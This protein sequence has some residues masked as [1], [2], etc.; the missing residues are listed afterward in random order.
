MIGALLSL[1]LAPPQACARA[2]ELAFYAG[3][4]G[5]DDGG[6]HS[7]AWQLEYRQNLWKYLDASF[8]YAN[9]GHVPGHHRDG[10]SLQVWAV[11]P[12]LKDRFTLALGVGPY[13]YADTQDQD[14]PPG[15]KDAHD[16]GMI[17]S[18]SFTWYL[19]RRWLMRVNVNEIEAGAGAN[20]RSYVLGLGYRLDQLATDLDQAFGTRPGYAD[21]PNEMTAFVGVTILNSENSENAAAVGLEYRR[22][23]ASYFQL[24]GAWFNEEA[25]ADKRYNSLA[26]QAWLVKSWPE[27][28]VSLGFGVGPNFALGDHV[29][30]DGRALKEVVGLASMTA[31]WRFS[32]ALQARLTWNRGFTADDQDRDLILLGIGWLWGGP[33]P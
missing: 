8:L 31:A 6:S 28:G 23:L 11:T 18:G 4:T 27:R 5:A 20:T 25:G 26:A 10:V 1:A 29:G 21:H 9:E 16:V 24:S 2:E 19:S 22:T 30:S 12:R 13:L 3:S 7:Y 17:Y 33:K 15:F 32:S 14:A